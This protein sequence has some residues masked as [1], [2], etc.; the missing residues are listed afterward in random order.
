MSTKVACRT[1]FIFLFWGSLWILVSDSTLKWIALNCGLTVAEITI[2]QEWKGILFVGTSAAIIFTTLNHSAKRF[3]HSLKEYHNLFRHNPVPMFIY[4]KSSGR[5]VAVNEAC[6]KQYG[7]THTQMKTLTVDSIRLQ[8]TTQSGDYKGL[9]DAGMQKHRKSDGTEF[10]IHKFA[11]DIEFDTRTT[12][13]VLAIDVNEEVIAKHRLMRQN[14]RLAELAWFESHEL[15]API[16]RML[17]LLSL[18]DHDNQNEEN[19]QI[20]QHLKTSGEE[21]DRMVRQLSGK[22]IIGDEHDSRVA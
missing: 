6:C 2:I 14:E 22:T 4:E 15:R 10:W 16:A 21:L 18:Y 19:K 9:Q 11:R 1:A 3:E 12:R 5:F 20:I 8:H 13:L 17:G 7:Y